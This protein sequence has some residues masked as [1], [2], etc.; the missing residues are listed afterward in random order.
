M[1]LLLVMMILSMLTKFGLDPSKKFFVS[2]DVRAF[3]DFTARGAK[4]ETEWIEKFAV[5]GA[6]FPELAA[7]F[8]RRLE[9]KLPDD[10]DKDLPVFKQED[11][12]IATRL[13][14]GNILNHFAK[15]M[16]ELFGGSAD[17]NPSCFTYLKTDKDFLKGHYDQRNVRFGVR[18]HAMASICNGLAAYGGFIPFCSTF[19]NFI[20]YAYGAVILTALSHLQ[21]LYVFTHDS[22]YLGEDGP[23]HQPIEKYLTCRGTPNLNFWR[24]ADCNE[25]LAAYVSAI[26]SN[27][28]PTVMS[29]TRQNLPNLAS[30][31]EKALCGGYVLE[32]SD[33]GSHPDVILVGTGSETSVCVAAAKKLKEANKDLKVRVAS[34]PCWELFDA[35]PQEYRKSVFPNGSLVVSVEAGATLGW[36]RYSHVAIGVDT[37]GASAP[38]SA[39]Q[40]HFGLTPDD[41]VAKTQKSLKFFE[42]QKLLS[43]LE[44]PFF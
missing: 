8:K 28:T 9:G 10:W 30:T 18:E 17:L 20:G 26:K 12:P 22:I 13:S 14:S 38:T 24:P 3:Y 33:V 44:R 27:K 23:T 32:E 25:T 35:Q 6:K 4:L 21:V 42:G 39:L 34:L 36:D 19:L 2:D 40:K 11:A 29:L 15:K 1:E 37:F 41:V 43:R 5:Y 31:V 7:E 16:P